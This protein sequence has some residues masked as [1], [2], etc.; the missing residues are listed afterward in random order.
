LKICH[1]KLIGLELV[2]FTNTI[3]FQVGVVDDEEIGGVADDNSADDV[4]DDNETQKSA[5]KDPDA[6]DQESKPVKFETSPSKTKIRSTRLLPHQDFFLF[7]TDIYD[8]Q[9]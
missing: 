5:P 4:K 1:L 7:V 2:F 8:I 9:A 6:A 3:F